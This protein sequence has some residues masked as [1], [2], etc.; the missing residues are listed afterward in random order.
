MATS[1]DRKKR[2]M[3]H[4]A[5]TTNEFVKPSTRLTDDRKRQIM[6][7]VRRTSG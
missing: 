1:D 6:D 4:L 3:E 5:R 2:I 7:H